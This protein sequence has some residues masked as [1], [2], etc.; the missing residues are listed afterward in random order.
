MRDAGFGNLNILHGMKGLK[1]FIG[2]LHWGP[3]LGTVNFESLVFETEVT[4]NGYT[5][6]HHTQKVVC[7]G[8]RS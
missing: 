3:S 4:F 8:G 1:T 6:A 7:I 2:D 5:I